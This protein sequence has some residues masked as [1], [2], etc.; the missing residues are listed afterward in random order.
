MQP[1][2]AY[3]PVHVGVFFVV[4]R[5]VFVWKA[6]Y[7]YYLFIQIPIDDLEFQFQQKLSI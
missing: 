5:L 7:G 2:S 3:T 1:N 6:K 4:H